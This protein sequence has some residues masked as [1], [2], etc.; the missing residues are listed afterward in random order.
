MMTPKE[1]KFKLLVGNYSKSQV[2]LKP[3]KKEIFRNAIKKLENK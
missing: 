1:N 2:K 3:T